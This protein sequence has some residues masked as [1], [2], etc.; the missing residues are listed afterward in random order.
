MVGNLHVV[1][2]VDSSENYCW[3][4]DT[5]LNTVYPMGSWSQHRAPQKTWLF[6]QGDPSTNSP[7]PKPLASLT[8][9]FHKAMGSVQLNDLSD[10]AFK[11][12][13][14]YTCRQLFQNISLQKYKLT[15]NIN[16][17]HLFIFIR[18]IIYK[19]QHDVLTEWFIF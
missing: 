13:R 11:T 19:L 7:T 3:V 2:W 5:G 17:L 1:A 6:V 4:A 15:Y 10:R 8:C 14:P 16:I 18:S 12:E 9:P